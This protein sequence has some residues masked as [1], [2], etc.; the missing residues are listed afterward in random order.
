MDISVR[1]QCR[2][3]TPSFVGLIDV[4]RI[5]RSGHSNR[6][7]PHWPSPYDPTNNCLFDQIV[8]SWDTANKDTELSN[9]SVCTTRGIKDQHA[10]LPDVYR[11]KLDFLEQKRAVRELAKLHQ[12]TIVLVEDKASGTSG[13]ARRKLFDHS[14]SSR[15][16]WRQDHTL[17]LTT[18]GT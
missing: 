18:A 9:F 11:H 14:G 2:K 16:R 8:Q 5:Q 4:N 7:W 13:I 12:A 17:T 6:G 10:F 15:D 1:R 3:N